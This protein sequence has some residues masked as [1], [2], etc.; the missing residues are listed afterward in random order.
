MYQGR[1]YEVFGWISTFVTGPSFLVIFLAKQI[2]DHVI[3]L[4]PH[5]ILYYLQNGVA[6]RAFIRAV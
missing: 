3:Y 5:R 4:R 2:W 6:I 1:V